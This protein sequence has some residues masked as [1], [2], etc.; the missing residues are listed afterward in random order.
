MQRGA[1]TK[2]LLREAT[3][4]SA[5]AQVF[6]ELNGERLF[7]G[8]GLLFRCEPIAHIHKTPSRRPAGQ[9]QS[10]EALESAYMAVE[11]DGL[12]IAKA[13][14][15]VADGERLVAAPKN[16][17]DLDLDG[18]KE[19]FCPLGPPGIAEL[20]RIAVH[21]AERKCPRAPNQFRMC[22]QKKVAQKIP[23]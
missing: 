18:M 8:S 5:S 13:I 9:F 3:T 7:V 4:P 6:A 21:F 14:A 1:K 23:I 22:A 17:D 2:L 20:S 19:S 12:D 10:T 16:L 15:Q 11:M